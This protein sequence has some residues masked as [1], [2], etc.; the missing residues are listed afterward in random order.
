MILLTILAFVSCRDTELTCGIDKIQ[1]RVAQY[2]YLSGYVA[3]MGECEN[4]NGTFEVSRNSDLSFGCGFL[5]RR[6]KLRIR[7]LTMLTFDG[8]ITFKKPQNKW[9]LTAADFKTTTY[10]QKVSCSYYLNTTIS[11]TTLNCM[12]QCKP[13]Q[14]IVEPISNTAA[15]N[16]TKGIFADEHMLR[17][18][19]DNS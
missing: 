17:T 18:Y 4:K 12:D 10:T 2:F 7:N 8:E 3:S 19:E 15:F 5:L 6:S 9:L 11:S 13:K 16:V 14:I 1:I